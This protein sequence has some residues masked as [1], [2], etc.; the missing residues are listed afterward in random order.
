MPASGPHEDGLSQTRTSLIA[1]HIERAPLMPGMDIAL[2]PL[3]PMMR[4]DVR[5]RRWK[6]GIHH[7]SNTGSRCTPLRRR[8]PALSHRIRQYRPTPFLAAPR[9]PPPL[10]SPG[11]PWCRRRTHRAQPRLPADARRVA[12]TSVTLPRRGSD[13]PPGATHPAD[14]LGCQPRPRCATRQLRRAQNPPCV[15]RL[16]GRSDR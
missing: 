6:N 14:L 9:R 16:M 11:R 5:K 8:R 15:T 7:N 1:P 10:T 2:P 13:D 12:S 4:T 3:S